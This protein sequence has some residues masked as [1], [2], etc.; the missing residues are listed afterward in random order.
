MCVC[1]CVSDYCLCKWHCWHLVALGDIVVTWLSEQCVKLCIADLLKVMH[2]LPK[3]SCLS[4]SFL[5][6]KCAR[7]Q[8]NTHTHTHKQV[9]PVTSV[10]SHRRSNCPLVFPCHTVI[11]TYPHLPS[12]LPH[13]N[14]ALQQLSHSWAA[15]LEQASD[16][17]SPRG[18][19]PK[20][21]KRSSCSSVSAGIRK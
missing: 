2:V 21:M 1:V 17:M 18:I 14:Q 19:T 10:L 6:C 20:A 9:P 11:P 13:C 15:L 4:V 16:T 3:E 7:T 12:N 8:T 5:T